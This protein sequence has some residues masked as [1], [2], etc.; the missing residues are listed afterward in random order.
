MH[1]LTE[2]FDRIPFRTF[3]EKFHFIDKTAVSIFVPR[4]CSNRSLVEELRKGVKVSMRKLQNYCCTVLCKELGV[5]LE[6]GAVKEYDGVYVLEN[7]DY[8]NP[9]IGIQLY[10]E[11]KFL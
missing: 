11:D 4:D 2:G 5:L 6:Q 3:S 10:G 1:T 8:Y 9:K 7:S